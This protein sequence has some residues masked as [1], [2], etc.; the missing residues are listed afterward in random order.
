MGEPLM[1]RDS[2]GRTLRD[3][4]QLCRTFGLKLN[5]TTNG[6]FHSPH[7]NMTVEQWAREL[8]PVL[9]DVKFSWN[10]ASS[11]VQQRVMIRSKFDTQVSSSLHR[12]RCSA[13]G[14]SLVL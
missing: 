6:T 12:L 4:I 13:P 8:C 14:S 9:S 7:L 1:Y 3:V 2:R 11:A 5:L 10:G